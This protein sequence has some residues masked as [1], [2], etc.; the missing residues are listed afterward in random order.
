MYF[1]GWSYKT[2]APYGLFTKV[3]AKL[4][5]GRNFGQNVAANVSFIKKNWLL[6]PVSEASRE[7]ANL[8]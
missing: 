8:L 7:V 2:C 5:L 4:K 6:S 1:C 3:E